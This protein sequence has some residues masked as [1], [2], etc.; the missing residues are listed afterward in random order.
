[1]KLFEESKIYSLVSLKNLIGYRKNVSFPR[2][3][4]KKISQ[5]NLGLSI[6][7]Q[8]NDFGVVCH[9]IYMYNINYL[10]NL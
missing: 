8:I 6:I 9:Y 1:M 2:L 4:K 3:I 7:I 10:V 5:V